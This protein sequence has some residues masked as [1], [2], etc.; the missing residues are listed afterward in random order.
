MVEIKKHDIKT[1]MGLASE[2]MGRVDVFNLEV[3]W[4]R[5]LEDQGV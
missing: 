2:E 4:I 1:L 3:L 5:R